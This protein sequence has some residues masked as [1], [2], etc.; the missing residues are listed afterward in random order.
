MS[1]TLA[2]LAAYLVGFAFVAGFFISDEMSFVNPEYLKVTL[3][4]A[5]WPLGIVLV[6]FQK[7]TG[8]YI[9]DKWRDFQDWN[10]QRKCSHNDT[11]EC[12]D[13]T[14]PSGKQGDKICR[15]CGKVWW[16]Q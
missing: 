9:G 3:F 12:G 7:V 10:E 1:V 13:Y 2:L 15:D 6:T 8:I 16:D 5:L 14:L 11:E 4:A